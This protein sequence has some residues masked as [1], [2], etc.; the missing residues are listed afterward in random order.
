[1][2]TTVLATM[3]FV[4]PLLFAQSPHNLKMQQR[5]DST[6][7]TFVDYEFNECPENGFLIYQKTTE[8]PACSEMN[9]EDFILEVDSQNIISINW[10]P[11]MQEM[12]IL[13]LQQQSQADSIQ[14]LESYTNAIL[15]DLSAHMD[16]LIDTSSE[17]DTVGA[18]V[19]STINSLNALSS[20]VAGLEL[21]CASITSATTLGCNIATLTNQSAVRFLRINADNSVTALT[22]SQL[23]AEMGMATPSI[24]SVT[25]PAL[26]A[27]TLLSST[28]DVE[29]NYNYEVSAALS[30]GTAIYLETFTNSACNSG[31]QE[32]MHDTRTVALGATMNLNVRGWV[33][34]GRYVK[35][36]NVSLVGATQTINARPGQERTE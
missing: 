4:S 26:G 22:A 31:T 5:S 11:L 23:M 20:Q 19:T 16:I 10:E 2:R 13:Q 12:D 17:L 6:P 28:R 8:R 35:T 14:V 29:V 7:Y 32:I 25:S 36:R 33:P 9:P 24:S 21:P 18:S 30:L 34:A 15:G 3:L 1:M 27:C